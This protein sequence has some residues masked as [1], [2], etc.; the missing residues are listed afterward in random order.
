MPTILVKRVS[1]ALLKDLKRLKVELGCRTWA[2]LLQRLVE[3]KGLEESRI[4]EIRKGVKGF[5]DLR[6]TVS[7]KWAG[8]PSVSEEFRRS[9][10]HEN[11]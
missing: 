8:A 4:E 9:R 3:S 11:R 2:E 10:G 7:E 6:N 1:E 5:L